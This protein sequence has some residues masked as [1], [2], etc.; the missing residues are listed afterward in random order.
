M[1]NFELELIDCFGL[2]R[3]C[4]HNLIVVIVAKVAKL[5]GLGNMSKLINF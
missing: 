5:A 4:L 3:F 1:Y 2:V